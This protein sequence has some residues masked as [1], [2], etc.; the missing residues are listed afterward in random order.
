MTIWLLFLL[1]WVLS[2]SFGASQVTRI[3]QHQI[4]ATNSQGT[5]IRGKI[6][7]ATTGAPVSDAEIRISRPGIGGVISS[8]TSAA[9][10]N[11]EVR[12][13]A[14]GLYN[15]YVTRDGFVPA[16]YLDVANVPVLELKAGQQ[17]AIELRLLPGASIAGVITDLT[18]RPIP[19]LTVKAHIQIYRHGRV[20]LAHRASAITNER[21]EYRLT[22]LLP[23]LYHLRSGQVVGRMTPATRVFLPTIYPG[24]IQTQDA[25]DLKLGQSKS[26]VNFQ[27][28]DAP[29]YSVSGR[30]TMIGTERPMVGMDITA[31]PD[32]GSSGTMVTAQVRADGSF[33]MAGLTRGRYRM[34][35][36][37]VNY[38]DLRPLRRHFLRFFEIVETDL[39]DMNI[40]VTP[41]AAVSGSVQ[42]I[43]EALPSGLTVQFV[44]RHPLERGAR[45]EVFEATVGRTG[46]FQIRLQP[47]TYDIQIRQ[48][49][50]DTVQRREFFVDPIIVDGRLAI[51]TGVRVLEETTALDVSVTM[52][53]RAGTVQGK[54]LDFDNNSLPGAKVTLMSADPEKRI[55]L[56]YW[57]ETNSDS[58][59]AFRFGA[60]PPGEYLL[61]F[62]PGH[63]DWS[64][65]EPEIFRVLERHA[66]RVRVAPSAV[67]V[68]N[69]RVTEEIRSAIDA[70]GK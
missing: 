27:L 56:P 68:Q 54:T 23:G 59:G 69:L 53:F 2:N 26:L 37:L 17:T 28:R 9:N 1:P 62:W 49:S 6:R 33:Q 5:L 18:G 67:A 14:P 66:A 8:A 38:D 22:N 3:V 60:L 19:H 45:V 4:S 43:G 50:S 11:F 12:E 39:T 64:V 21:G 30:V 42:A 70:L 47:G 46:P 52:D 44:L 48:N 29:K 40:R 41:G 55:L 20:Q 24:V 35:G 31:F 51:D 32:S 13:L 34:Q 25:I 65:L 10:G 63:L 7:N 61:M 15:I 57:K 16:F 58:Q 36:M